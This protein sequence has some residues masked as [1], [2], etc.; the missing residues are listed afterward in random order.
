MKRSLVAAL[1]LSSTS[2]LAQEE[3]N[4]VGTAAPATSAATTGP[5]RARTSS[6]IRSK[7]GEAPPVEKTGP[8]MT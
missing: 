8:S 6:I 5:S 3:P 1:L 7:V 4:F 2:A